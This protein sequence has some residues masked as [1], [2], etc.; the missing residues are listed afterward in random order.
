MSQALQNPI[1]LLDLEEPD[2]R[3]LRGVSA[4]EDPQRLHAGGRPGGVGG[5]EG[6]DSPDR[7]LMLNKSRRTDH[8]GTRLHVLES[9]HR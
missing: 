6:V 9:D 8:G 5:S 7:G 3:I 2:V 4:K 1:E